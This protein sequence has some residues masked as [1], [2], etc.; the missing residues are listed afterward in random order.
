MMINSEKL[1]GRMESK[2][3]LLS[4]KSISNM[5]VI[6]RR[7]VDIDGMLKDKLVLAKVREGIR[8]QEEERLRRVEREDDIE[9]RDDDDRDI[10]MDD[11]KRK[12]KKPKPGGPSNILGP[13]GAILTGAGIALIANNLGTFR[14]TA[15]VLKGIGSVA[16]STFMGAATAI[17]A[18]Y[19]IV[20]AIE[21]KTLQMFGNKGLQT[22]KQFQKVFS[23]FVNV[24]I[25][26][27]VTAGGVSVLGKTRRSLFPGRFKRP[28]FDSNEIAGITDLR[29][30]PTKRTIGN[31]EKILKKRR[32]VTLKSVEEIMEG[33][34]KRSRTMTF[35]RPAGSGKP[36]P[37][38][39]VKTIVKPKVTTFPSSPSYLKS[40]SSVGG[41][42]LCN[43]KSSS[44]LWT[45]VPRGAHICLNCSILLRLLSGIS[46]P[47]ID[48]TEFSIVSLVGVQT[49][50]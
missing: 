46:N 35:F 4:E 36:I 33:I 2:G 27:A 43:K 39:K 19:N 22:L 34:N 38:K 3:T 14:V 37:L 30:K 7:L 29:T 25:V 26:T 8:R 49:Y 50:L 21:A 15:Q 16:V 11:G 1:M 24:A 10:D 28:K 42:T 40:Y 17:N 48:V 12:R 13:A 44:A 41:S 9:E 31:L 47:L 23:T 32:G 45:A 5:G 18:G 6:R 20:N